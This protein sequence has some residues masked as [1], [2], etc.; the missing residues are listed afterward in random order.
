MEPKTPIHKIPMFRQQQGTVAPSSGVGKFTFRPP[1][2]EDP[3]SGSSMYSETNTVTAGRDGYKLKSVPNGTRIVPS[4]P[5]EEMAWT[6]ADQKRISEQG[7]RRRQDEWAR[8]TQ[9]KMEKR[10]AGGEDQG[11]WRDAWKAQ[12]K[13]A[14][15]ENPHKQYAYDAKRTRGAGPVPGHGGRA[16]AL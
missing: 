8:Q 11:D 9:R 10:V 2:R 15:E 1:P 13:R 4:Y 5:V 12:G 6:G 7:D 14:I 16:F 3:I